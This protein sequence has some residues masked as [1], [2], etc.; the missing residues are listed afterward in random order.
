MGL[1]SRVVPG[2]E[3]MNAARELAGQLTDKDPLVL[4]AAKQVL[5][6][7][8]AASMEEAMRNEEKT[9]GELREARSR[10]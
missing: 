10:K 5:T 8:E 3:L 9:S 7:G 2:E 1:G 6:F 4:A